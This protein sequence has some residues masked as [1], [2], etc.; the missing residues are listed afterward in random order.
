MRRPPP[1]RQFQRAQIISNLFVSSA[2]SVRRLLE[3]EKGLL[4]KNRL[5]MPLLP[6]DKFEKWTFLRLLILFALSFSTAKPRAKASS[7]ELGKMDSKGRFPIRQKNRL[8][9][10]LKKRR[11]NAG[12]F[13]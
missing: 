7:Y 5:P 12:F 4:L 10:Q 1:S 6:T 13:A 11:F 3:N 8:H 9:M 2:G